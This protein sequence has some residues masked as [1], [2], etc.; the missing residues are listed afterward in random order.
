MCAAAKLLLAAFLL[1][2]A[3]AQS[4]RIALVTSET[5]GAAC[6]VPA[7]GNSFPIDTPRL[8]A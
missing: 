2:P 6:A 1:T 3:V 7:A 8:Y 5:P 4:L